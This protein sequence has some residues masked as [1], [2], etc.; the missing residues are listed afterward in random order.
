MINKVI[1]VGHLGRDPEVRHFEG[2]SSVASFSVATSETYTDKNGERQKMTDWHNVVL[3][4][5][6]AT[7]AEN[8][9]KK[10][11]LVY[12]EGRL[13]TRK[14]QDKDGNDKYTTEIVG[15]TLKMLGGKG[16]GSGNYVPMPSASDAPGQ[17]V[18]ET[19]GKLA[20]PTDTTSAATPTATP[21]EKVEA[22]ADDDLP[23]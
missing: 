6:L 12:V 4:G 9:L 10:G 3:W 11:K 5:G 15:R 13:T 18:K 20:A 14:W 21:V 22:A 8:Y 17:L 23:F 1:I 19:P 16:E 2:N 7:V